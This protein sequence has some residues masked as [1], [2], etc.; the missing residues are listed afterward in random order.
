LPDFNAG[1]TLGELNRCNW[2]VWSGFSFWDTTNQSAFHPS[3]VNV[4]S[5]TLKLKARYRFDRATPHCGINPN[6]SS[7]PT[8]ENYYQRECK[9]ELGGVDSAPGNPITRGRT[10]Q[11]GRIEIR[12]KLPGKVGSGPAIWSWPV[13]L[14]EGYPYSRDAW[15]GYQVG[16]HDLL[17]TH[18]RTP[19]VVE[20]FSTFH[21]WGPPAGKHISQSSK[22]YNLPSDTWIR[23]G[24][25]RGLDRDGATRIARMYVNDGKTSCVVKEIRQGQDGFELSNWP[26]FLILQMAAESWW[27]PLSNVDGAT[28][29]VDYVRMY[30][31]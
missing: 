27:G 28:F 16:E 30:E 19:G 22:S 10:F 9:I 17:E 12:A 24:L 20:G 3:L 4:S 2:N 25:E 1:A 11:D 21:D 31:R 6:Q 23:F 26:S 13:L 15:N 5:G 7:D 14:N 8:N 29:E 18:T